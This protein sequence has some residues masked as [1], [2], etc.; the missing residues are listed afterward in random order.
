M[1]QLPAEKQ[2]TPAF[3]R[4]IQVHKLW[5]K[6]YSPK[7]LTAMYL[8][9]HML[10][11]FDTL[12]VCCGEQPCLI[13]DTLKVC[14]VEQPCVIILTTLSNSTDGSD[15]ADCSDSAYS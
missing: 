8:Y 9:D 6:V 13:F 5:T 1:P 2:K 10:K 14:C 15:S 11:M 7:G 12:K 3:I 4:E